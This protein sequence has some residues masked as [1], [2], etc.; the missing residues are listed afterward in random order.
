MIIFFHIFL[1]RIYQSNLYRY[2]TEHNFAS[3]YA[4]IQG[5]RQGITSSKWVF[6]D[7][8]DMNRVTR[9]GTTNVAGTAYPLKAL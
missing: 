3:E 1:L 4:Y 5:K 8:T 7:G 6:D 2:F 9:R